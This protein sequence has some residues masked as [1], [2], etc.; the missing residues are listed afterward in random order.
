[1]KETEVK[2]ETQITRRERFHRKINTELKEQYNF[3]K[4]NKEVNNI[5]TNTYMNPNNRIISQSGRYYL[6]SGNMNNK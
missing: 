6:N 1:M 5:N 3:N 4:N 2:N